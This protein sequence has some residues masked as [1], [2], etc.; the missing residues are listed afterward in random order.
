MH[1]LQRRVERLSGLAEKG[2]RVL[3]QKDQVT[4]RLTPPQ[5]LRHMATNSEDLFVFIQDEKTI[6]ELTSEVHE[7]QQTLHKYKADR[8]VRHHIYQSRLSD[9][10]RRQAESGLLHLFFSSSPR[11]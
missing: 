6:A 3:Q 7:M 8:Y 10:A 11:T 9:S 5:Q 2:S 4:G 1:E